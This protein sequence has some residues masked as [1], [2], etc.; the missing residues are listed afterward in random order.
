MAMFSKVVTRTLFSWPL[1]F[2]L[3]GPSCQGLFAD[4]AD[5]S[6]QICLLAATP[7]EHTGKTYPARAY[8][9]NQGKKLKLVREVVPQSD[10]VRFAQGWGPVVFLV[11]P[12]VI[13]TSVAV[14]HLNEPMAK[15]DLVFNAAGSLLVDAW[16]ALAEPRP[17]SL[18]ALLPLS[19]GVSGPAGQKNTVVG[20]SSNAQQASVRI[21]G[22]AWAEYSALRREGHHGGPAVQPYLIGAVVDGR[23]VV[24]IFGRPVVIDSATFLPRFPAANVAPAIVAASQEHLVLDVQYAAD[25]TNLP[26]FTDMFV[27]DRSSN[28]WRTVRV[29]GNASNS[30]LF[31]PWLAITVGMRNPDH[32]TSPGRENERAY[33]T[34]MLPNVRQQYAIF[35]GKWIWSPGVLALQ[36]LVDGRKIRIETGQE[37][38]EILRVEG[39]IVLYRVNDA[40]YQARIAGDQLKDTTLVVKDEDVPEIHWVF[41]SK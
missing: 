16:V 21:T 41:W 19:T 35:Q 30:R 40:I 7:T 4:N 34:D 22:D 15:D 13:S 8:R 26:D 5:N 28:R 14:V 27:H 25:A 29:E 18:D 2:I 1:V 39:D 12:H 36:N 23:L 11:H 17:Y 38:S 20:I 6:A 3:A 10:G 32:K 31:D 9:V 37:D 33:E 24:T